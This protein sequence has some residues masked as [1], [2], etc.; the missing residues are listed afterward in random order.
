MK[1]SADSKTLAQVRV[2]AE[3]PP[4][5]FVVGDLHGCFD[6]LQVMLAHLRNELSLS[7]DDLLIFLGDYIDR[8]PKSKEVIEQMLAIKRERPNTVFLKGNHEDMLL[9][10][11]GHGGE[12]GDVYLE[13]GGAEFLKSYGL[14]PFATREDILAA[15]SP[16]HVEFLQSL[17]HGVMLAEFLFVHAGINP[18]MPL[19]QQSVHDVLWIRGNFT[20][21]PHSA[22]KT[23]VFGHTPFEDVFLDL[24]YKIG[25]DTGLV[26]GN[27]LSVLELVH[28]QLHQVEHGEA[29]A[30]TFS[31]R[32]R[33]GG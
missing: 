10:Y 5:V 20:H 18:S 13:N 9:D 31:L 4:R 33:L 11:L 16:E 27:R 19:D 24:P 14:H 21:S 32:E 12:C 8:G 28:G 23:V 30:K 2:I 15:I 25:V 29:K 6:E 3:R 26:F 1:T 22:G 17:E 7:P